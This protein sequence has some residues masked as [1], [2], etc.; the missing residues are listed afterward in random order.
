MER[1]KD[2]RSASDHHIDLEP[3]HSSSEDVSGQQ[4]KKHSIRS[5]LTRRKQ[6]ETARLDD[7]DAIAPPEARPHADEDVDLSTPYALGFLVG[8]FTWVFGFMLL[9]GKGD[10]RRTAALRRGLLMGVTAVTLPLASVLS[11]IILL[12]KLIK[13]GVEDLNPIP[14]VSVPGN[15]FSN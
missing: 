13:N 6:A 7:E 1:A 11:L 9:F 2:P 14:D 12:F 3:Y 15:P 10:P 4:G 5:K 8:W